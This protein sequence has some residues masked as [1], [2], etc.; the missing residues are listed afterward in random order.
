MP[1]DLTKT[2]VNTGKT[3][4]Q[5]LVKEYEKYW[6]S[7]RWYAVMAIIGVAMIIY[8]VVSANYLFTL[9]VVLVGIVTFLH[10]S[11]EPRD[12][13]FAIMER[14]ILLGKKFYLFSELKN[15]WILYDPPYLKQLY[16]ELDNMLKH[17]LYVP[18]MDYDPRPIREYLAKYLEEDLEQDEEPMI[19]R[20]TRMIK[21][22]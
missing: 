1:V 21:I 7:P 22:G 17:R 11:Q 13:P 3:V 4:Y 14:G 15:F 5:W 16:F 20:L 8:S 6:R 10:D 18:L 9:I 12:V 2:Q 19:D